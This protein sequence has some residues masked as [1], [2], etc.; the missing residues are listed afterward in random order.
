[1]QI[2]KYWIPNALQKTGNVRYEIVVHKFWTSATL[3]AFVS[4]SDNNSCIVTFE[5]LNMQNNAYYKLII[6]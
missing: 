1:M 2:F 5:F 4:L 6:F 3:G